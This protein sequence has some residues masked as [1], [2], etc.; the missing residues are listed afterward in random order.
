MFSKSNTSLVPPNLYGNNSYKQTLSPTY[1]RYKSA[2]NVAFYFDNQVCSNTKIF[3]FEIKN[4]SIKQ[5][6]N[7]M[8]VEKNNKQSIFVSIE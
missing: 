1:S 7:R 6:G 4:I 8:I 3:T 5:E 2:P